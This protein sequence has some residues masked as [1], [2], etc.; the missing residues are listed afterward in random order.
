MDDTYSVVHFFD[1]VETLPS[2]WVKG[3]YCAWPKNNLFIKKF[4]EK[5]LATNEKEF[6]YLKARLLSRNIS[7]LK[8]ITF[9]YVGNNH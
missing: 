8:I 1:D 4:I 7:K 5:K 6:K 3:K 9:I 2:F